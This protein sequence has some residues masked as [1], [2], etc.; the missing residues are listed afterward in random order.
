MYN[1]KKLIDS[2][3]R[4]TILSHLHPD[5]DTIST[6]LGIYAILKKYKKIVVVPLLH[7]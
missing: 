6:A 7:N 3:S 4:V 5:G 2:Y 1:I